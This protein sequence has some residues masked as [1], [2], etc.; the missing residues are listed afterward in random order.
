MPLSNNYLQ[1]ISRKE[2]GRAQHSHYLALSQHSFS[3]SVEALTGGENK[4]S[5]VTLDS[6]LSMSGSHALSLQSGTLTTLGCSRPVQT[7]RPHHPHDRN[8]VQHVKSAGGGNCDVIEKDHSVECVSNLAWC[9][10]WAPSS[11]EVPEEVISRL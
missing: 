6:E 7:A 10:I 2:A 3:Q 8:L 1:P 9:V 5:E 11:R 4:W